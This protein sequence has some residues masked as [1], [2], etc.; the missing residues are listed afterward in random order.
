MS[1][2]DGLTLVISK[3]F[4]LVLL[5]ALYLAGTFYETDGDC[6]KPSAP[7]VSSF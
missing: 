4:D 2:S 1:F 6:S 5:N 3:S 7:R